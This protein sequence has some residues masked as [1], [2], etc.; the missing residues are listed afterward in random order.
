MIGLAEQGFDLIQVKREAGQQAS[1]LKRVTSD[2]FY[3]L[4]REI[5]S[6]P[7]LPG[8][9]DFRLM[10]RLVVDAIA[11]M[12]ERHRF[13]RGMVAWLGFRTAILPYVPAARLGG[14]SKYS[15]KKM[16]RLGVD[17]IYSFSLAPIIAC[18][19]VSLLFLISALVTGIIGLTQSGESVSWHPGLVTLLLFCTGVILFAI[20]S[21]GY[22]SGM[23]FQQVKWRPIYLV[24]S[25][26]NEPPVKRKKVEPRN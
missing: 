18:L 4:I 3:K 26:I 25:D 10:N 15:I 13:L 16:F 19:V 22:Y 2:L 20:G 7:I 9:G 6:T 1:W 23:T 14:R 12:P 8:V 5:T 21:V 11:G 17:A 24:R